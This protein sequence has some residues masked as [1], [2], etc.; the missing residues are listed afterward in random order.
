MSIIR[1]QAE[2]NGYAGKAV[3]LLG[4]LD[5][6]SGLLIISK[7]LPAGERSEEALIIANDPRCQHRDTLFDEELLQDAIRL[8]FRAK[9]TGMVE[10]LPAIAKHDPAHKIE[11]DG[12]GENGTKYRLA[13]D[14]SNGHIGVLALLLQA[15]NAN[16]G[17]EVA[18][19]SQDL[20]ELF[21]TI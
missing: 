13:A 6:D 4:A 19:F 14:I 15:E 2:I 1:I 8:Y 9:S 7:D 21:M 11:N 20:A 18:S 17:N 12:V 16:K 5:L 3:N 10:L